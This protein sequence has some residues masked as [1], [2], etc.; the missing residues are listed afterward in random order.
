MI[1]Q[2]ED[3]EL[4]DNIDKRNIQYKYLLEQIEVDQRYR[5]IQ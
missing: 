2:I 4:V 5:R 1:A 3:K